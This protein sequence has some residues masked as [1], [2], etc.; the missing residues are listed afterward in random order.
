MLVVD[1]MAA[2]RAITVSQ[3][4]VNTVLARTKKVLLG[5]M[6]ERVKIVASEIIC[7][8]LLCIYMHTSFLCFMYPCFMI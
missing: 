1:V 3:W 7:F 2:L 8:H 6:T 4:I 5:V